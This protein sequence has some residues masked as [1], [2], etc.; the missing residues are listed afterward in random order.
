[1]SGVLPLYN[2]TAEKR[3]FGKV[4]AKKVERVF[5]GGAKSSTGQSHIEQNV[6]Q[7]ISLH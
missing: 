6:Y 5:L 4:G 7:Y 2:Y 1:M 3:R